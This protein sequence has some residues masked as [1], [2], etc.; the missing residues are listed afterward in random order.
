MVDHPQ[1]VTIGDWIRNKID[2]SNFTQHFKGSYKGQHYCSDFPPSQQFSNHASCKAFSDF[3][4]KEISK[5]LTT[6]ALRVWG[7]VSDDSPSY[8]VLP[9]TV[10]PTKPR[11]CIDARF[12]NLWMRDAPFSLDRL[13]DVPR[14]ASV[15]QSSQTY[16]GFQWN[17]FWFVCTTLSFGWKISPYIYHTIDLVASGYL[18]ARGIPRSLYIDDRLNRERVTTQGP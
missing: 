4:S 5:R 6:G 8:L 17:G 2:I 10:E 18:R 15:S 14:Y 11:L 16:V 12:L 3:V 7:N 1:K 13:A 9:L